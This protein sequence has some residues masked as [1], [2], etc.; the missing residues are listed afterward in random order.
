MHL[1]N[2]NKIDK[3]A[4]QDIINSVI[5]QSTTRNSMEKNESTKRKPIYSV[6]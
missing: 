5:N 2:G 3:E 6:I 4:L 1:I